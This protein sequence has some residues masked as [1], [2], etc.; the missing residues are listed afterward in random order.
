MMTH[1]SHLARDPAGAAAAEMALVVPLLLALML[2]SFD[3][4]NYFLSEHV[5]QKSVRDAARYAA[6]LPLTDYPACVPLSATTT[7]IQQVARTGRPDGT[8]G[9]RLSG[10]TNNDTVSV[11]VDCTSGV[12][13]GIYTDF[14][15]GAPVFTVSA[16]VPYPSL[17]GVLGLGSPSLSLNATSQ[18]AAFGA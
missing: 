1:V 2:G 12:N 16:A 10:W 7:K 13:T 5:V 18:A 17:F 3:L 4:G 14:P 15:N 11:T 6:R 9:I 8:G